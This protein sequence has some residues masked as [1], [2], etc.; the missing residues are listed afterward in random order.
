MKLFSSFQSLKLFKTLFKFVSGA[1][2]APVKCL[3]TTVTSVCVCVLALAAMSG[4][5]QTCVCRYER[6]IPDMFV[7]IGMYGLC[8][9]VTLMF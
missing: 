2:C 8:Y 3:A 9:Y 6:A 1:R 7:C 5:F 4:P